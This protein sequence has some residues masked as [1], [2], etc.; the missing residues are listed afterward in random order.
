MEPIKQI[1][2]GLDM[3]ALDQTLIEFAGFISRRGTVEKV[4]FM[5]IIRATDMSPE[6]KK[7]FPNL[8]D[9]MVRERKAKI[10]E[11]VAEYFRADGKIKIEFI[12]KHGSVNSLLDLAIKGSADLIIIGQKKDL[13]GT[14][15]LAQR[16]ARRATCNL[17]IVPEG[18]TPSISRLLLPV[19]FS[20]YSRM[21]LEAVIQLSKQRN[22]DIEVFC[23]NV[24]SVPAGYHYTG[25]SYEEFS[26]I[27]RQHA[28][29]DFQRLI[30][31][32]DTK[33]VK[34]TPVYSLDDNDNLAS[35][36][37][38]L[39]NEIKPDGIV[40]GAKGR[41]AAASLLLGSMAEKLI[42]S[43]MAFPLLIIRP[44][45]KSAG[46]LETFRDIK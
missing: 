17:L 24:Y 46:L 7:Q 14:G 27:M 21:A 4:Q 12:I 29:K 18:S 35:D 5:S 45:G 36:V 33:G 26:E 44:R 13:P 37:Y 34:I 8:M 15:V 23:Q 41:T 22:H 3:T 10:K 20:K 39:A 6:L 19:D 9:D 42:N 11:K 28:E 43:K 25:K 1:L 40:I 30:S 31:R 32:V 38:D 16:L 2:V